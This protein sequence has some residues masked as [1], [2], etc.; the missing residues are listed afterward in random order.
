MTPERPGGR[1]LRADAE[2]NRRR[3]LAAAAEV[4]AERGLDAGLDEIARRAGVGTGTVYRRFP[5]KSSLIEAL[6]VSRLDAIVEVTEQARQAPDGWT[7]LVML[8]TRAVEMQ[9]ADRGLK[10]LLYGDVS[11]SATMHAHVEE[12]MA[13]VQPTFGE[14]LD[15]AKAEG[16]VRDEVS[17]TDLSVAMFMLHG[18]GRFSAPDQ[19]RRQ[20]ALVLAGLRPGSGVPLPGSPL[21]ERELIEACS[22]RSPAHV[23]PQTV[24]ITPP[25]TVTH[26]A[27]DH[28]P[29]AVAPD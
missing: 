16:A 1:P 10:E 25:I 14:I 3:I 19:W 2:R 23:S 6:F 13:T 24:P 28:L 7:G 21:T 29:V 27:H 9:L 4:F 20:L 12:R 26:P 5:D 17:V 8:L 22:P 11:A 18:V 15:R